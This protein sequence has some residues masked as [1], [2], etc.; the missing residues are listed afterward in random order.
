MS[1]RLM[2]ASVLWTLRRERLSANRVNSG[3][4]PCQAGV[5]VLKGN[6]EPSLPLGD[7][8]GRTVHSL[9]VDVPNEYDAHER[10]TPAR[11]MR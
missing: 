7:S 3:K 6:P 4:L 5:P 1:K 2:A 10:P 11:V 9:G 8:C